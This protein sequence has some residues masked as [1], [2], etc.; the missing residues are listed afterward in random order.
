MTNRFFLCNQLC[1]QNINDSFVVEWIQ[2]QFNLKQ[3][4]DSKISLLDSKQCFLSKL[5]SSF[6]LH[7]DLDFNYFINPIFTSQR[8]KI[9]SK[10]FQSQDY[11]KVGPK[12]CNH[13]ISFKFNNSTHY[14]I[15]KYFLK[16]STEIFLAINELKVFG[17]LYEKLGARTSVELTNLRNQGAFSRFFCY[18][19]EIDNF[20]IIH[21]SLVVSKCIAFKIDS[22][23]YCLS[24]YI[25]LHE[26]S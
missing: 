5:E 13:I 23:T 19:K 6:N 22:L 20:N 7:C 21:S 16:I 4:N 9:G 3:F 25:D 11:K 18:C 17:N 8:L 14:G 12:K 15:I 24:E 2:S 1:Q 26:H 10:I